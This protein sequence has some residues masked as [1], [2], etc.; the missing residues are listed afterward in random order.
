M[1]FNEHEKRKIHQ[2]AKRV[3]GS[4]VGLVS[5]M[6][7][8]ITLERA[9]EICADIYVKT[10]ELVGLINKAEKRITEKLE[11]KPTTKIRLRAGDENEF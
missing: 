9:R 4:S 10:D 11:Y 2:G 8:H 5:I 1:E 6:S 7:N 3:M